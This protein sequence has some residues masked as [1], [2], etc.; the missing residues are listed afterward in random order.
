MMMQRQCRLRWWRR[1]ENFSI[2]TFYNLSQFS[3]TLPVV[4]LK[5]KSKQ[6]ADDDENNVWRPKVQNQIKKSGSEAGAMKKRNHSVLPSDVIIRKARDVGKLKRDV[7][8]K[9]HAE[10]IK[11]DENPPEDTEPSEA[12]VHAALGK[13]TQF[14]EKV[15]QYLDVLRDI[16]EDPPEIDD[17][18]DLMRRQKR[19]IEFSNRFARNHLYQIGRTVRKIFAACFTFLSILFSSSQA[20]ELRIAPDNLIELAT[21]SSVLF[22]VIMQGVSSYLKNV[23]MFICNRFPEKLLV[24]IDF[25]INAIKVCLDRMVFDKRDSIIQKMLRKSLDIKRFLEINR[26]SMAKFSSIQEKRKQSL[27]SRTSFAHEFPQDTK[28]SMYGGAAVRPKKSSSK[29][30]QFPTKSPYDAPTQRCLQTSRSHGPAKVSSSRNAT[31]S[32]VNSSLLRKSDSNVSTMM[33]RMKRKEST[34]SITTVP[35][36]LYEE[37]ASATKPKEQEIK[38]MLESIAM[39]KIQEMLGPLVAALAAKKNEKE[40]SQE[41]KAPAKRVTSDIAKPQ[42]PRQPPSTEITEAKTP[43]SSKSP[44]TKPKHNDKVQRISKNVQYLYV[45][46]NDEVKS[47]PSSVQLTSSLMCLTS[48]DVPPTKPSVERQLKIVSS[49]AKPPVSSDTK[50]DEEFTR[51]F[52]E[53]AFKDRMAYAEQ[54][55]ENPLYSNEVIDEPWRMFGR[56]D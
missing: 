43:S 23:E 55:A 15:C 56:W 28:L 6:H 1:R 39:S 26:Q 33:Q 27:C 11:V 29:P 30:K 4:E 16:I 52:K 9:S 21:K 17:T 49:K 12:D 24:L 18:N 53:Q 42:S 10:V 19:A 48:S 22:Q 7:N 35:E 37:N 13:V 3:Q 2:Y 47:V 36:Q 34:Q 5:R 41:P 46:S 14:Q 38:E 8:K 20:E 44:P 45:K 51:Q 32:R 50:K 54:M 25:I 40:S 31:Q